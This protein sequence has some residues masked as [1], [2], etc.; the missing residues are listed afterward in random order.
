MKTRNLF[1]CVLMAA[2]AMTLMVA[3]HKEIPVSSISVSPTS[4]TLNEGETGTVTA[5]V[6]PA[7]A[8]TNTYTWSSDNTSVATVS[9]TGLV[10]AV[11]A[12]TAN[13]KATTTDG[14]KTATCAVTVNALV[15][16]VT[17][18]QTAVTLYETETVTL[19]AT[20]S[21]SNA[22]NQNVTWSSSDESVATVKDGV[23]TAKKAGTATITVT[24]ADG[25]KT[26]TCSITVLAHVA[27]I[28]LDKEEATI[29]EG[30]TVTL[31]A[32]ITPDNATNKNITW[33]TSDENVATVKD[34]VV[35]G[36]NVG[37]ATI[38][39]TTED[40][41]YTAT[42]TIT[43]KAVVTGVKLDR[44]T[45]KV[46]VGQKGNLTATVLPEKASNKNITWS[47]SDETIATVVDG[48]V[49]GVKVGTVTITVKTEDGGKTA[50]C[51]VTVTDSQ[52]FGNQDYD[53]EDWNW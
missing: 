10:T 21:P 37:T 49:T 5:T 15:S 20:I 40:G 17:L 27:G 51:T 2:A 50:T 1:S 18:D 7:D 45:L 8:T 11:K 39:V 4:L 34:G 38:T 46:M 53:D 19:K 36:V 43:V 47:T 26:A 42:C 25:G 48:V 24:T 22:F 44:E 52:G 12:G 41:E 33:S 35:T 30:E 28:S 9:S 16:G 14:G 29:N 13:I 32:T 6:S 3:C 23:V 31:T